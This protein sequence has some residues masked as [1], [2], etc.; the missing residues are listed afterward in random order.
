MSSPI[1]VSLDFP[2]GLLE[3]RGNT[4]IHK[5]RIKSS[6]PGCRWDG[7]RKIWIAPY[8]QQSVEDI[9]KLLS[10]I[11]FELVGFDQEQPKTNSLPVA[12]VPDDAL[13][14]GQIRANIQ[15][16]LRAAIGSVRVYGV[17]SN[18]KYNAARGNAFF[19]LVETTNGVSAS[20]SLGCAVFEG[21]V[22]ERLIE[23][24]KGIVTDYSELDNLE[25][26]VE[27]E[28]TV[29]ARN[30]IS[31]N[32]RNFDASYTITR[33]RSAREI[34]NQRLKDEGL[35]ELQKGLRLP[36]LPTRIGVITSKVGT[37]IHDFIQGLSE[38]NYEF[39][40]T[41]VPTSVQGEGAES[42]IIQ[43]IRL[44]AKDESLD[45]I[46][47]FRGGGSA[48]DLGVFNSYNIAREIC[49]C[50]KPILCAIGHKE[51]ECSAQDVSYRALPLPNALGK[52]F[53]E[54]VRDVREGYS[55]S[56]QAINREITR[57]VNQRDTQLNRIWIET[58]SYVRELLGGCSNYLDGYR[59]NLG[60]MLSKY[61]QVREL[62]VN[63]RANQ[64]TNLGIRALGLQ[65]RKIDELSTKVLGLGKF[66]NSMKD[67]EVSQ[68]TQEIIRRANSNIENSNHRVD[69]LSTIVNQ[70]SPEVQL[71]RGY[72]IVRK[73]NNKLPE[74][75]AAQLAKGESL[76]IQFF[77]GIIESTVVGK[78][79][80]KKE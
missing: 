52:Y 58:S 37:V 33:I 54:R 7:A 47:I 78:R 29:T 51:D 40:L 17:I 43:A 74:I 70:S 76:E 44:L 9:S 68:L 27:G 14:V 32:V 79:D 67:K 6:F 36:M 64:V 10:G 3:F 77:D 26:L 45:A 39:S 20:P 15:T 18:F 42:A 69:L 4:F 46:A 2:A 59:S 75:R 62:E 13:S 34:T 1:F 28:I 63:K 5:D 61:I 30:F 19:D 57:I 24:L 66:I 38:A 49:L 22:L 55:G 23:N 80:G 48:V 21:I 12:A 53:S 73:A 16:A 65:H 71:R 8:R 31:L 41:W 35:F 25:V 60:Q 11:S 50:K 56:L 72:A